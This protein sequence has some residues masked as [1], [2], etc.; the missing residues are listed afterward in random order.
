MLNL[1][2]ETETTFNL[3]AVYFFPFLCR[4]DMMISK[5]QLTSLSKKS[6]KSWQCCGFSHTEW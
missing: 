4:H 6:D 2:F 1:T 5:Y 3:H